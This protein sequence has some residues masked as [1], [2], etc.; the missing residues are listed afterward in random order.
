MKHM[1]KKNI[2][3][4]GA[5][6]YPLLNLIYMLKLRSIWYIFKSGY[7]STQLKYCGKNLSVCS[8]FLIKGC[9]YISFGDNFRCQHF[10]RIEAWDSYNNE[11]FKPSIS[12][13]HNVSF[14]D[15]CHI[16]AVSSIYIGNNCLFGSNVYITDH[17]HGS[18]EDR[19]DAA[20]LDRNLYSKGPIFIDDN[21]WVGDNVVILPNVKIGKNVIVGANSVVNKDVPD[22]CVVAGI[23]AHVII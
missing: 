6:F 12:I 10:F 20:P 3:L 11:E 4:L 9:Q 5:F 23:P 14:S 22:F 7:L 15:R 16:G 1:L 17:Y 2:Y 8:S 18:V 13:G 21:V 19:F